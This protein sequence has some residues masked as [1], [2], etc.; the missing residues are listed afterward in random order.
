M[1]AVIVVGVLVFLT[2]VVAILFFYRRIRRYPKTNNDRNL[3]ES[4]IADPEELVNFARESSESLLRVPLIPTILP[5]HSSNPFWPVRSTSPILHRSWT[6]NTNQ[7]D[8]NRSV[9]TA[10][11][12][13]PP[14][15]VSDVRVEDE[16]NTAAVAN[17]EIKIMVESVSPSSAAPEKKRTFKMQK[18]KKEGRGED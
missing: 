14:K 10:P 18:V 3:G 17:T 1:I 2:G 9:L 7:G 6:V 5:N 8:E 16:T 13:P 4:E 12:V 15:V 11:S